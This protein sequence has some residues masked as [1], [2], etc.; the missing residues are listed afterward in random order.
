MAITK[1]QIERRRRY[2]G[3]SDIAAICGLSP[4]ATAR[5]VW[6]RKVYSLAPDKETADTSRGNYLEDGLLRFAEQKSGYR[7]ARNQFRTKGVFGANLDGLA[8]QYISGNGRKKKEYLP[9]GFEAKTTNLSAE[10]GEEDTDQVPDYVALQCHHQIYCA[11]LER[12]FVPV[13]T[14]HFG[15]LNMRMYRIERDDEVIA[16]LVKIGTD[17][18]NKHIVQKEPPPQDEP[19]RIE[20]LKRI[21]RVPEKTTVIPT[22]LVD[23]WKKFRQERLDAEKR[24]KKAFAALLESLEDAEAGITP[25]GEWFTYLEQKGADRIDR[26]LLKSRFPEVYSEVAMPTTYRVARLKNLEEEKK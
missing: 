15:R 25:E 23:N 7:I 26:K 19:A 10:W 8:F 21:E 1:K 24:E 3:S 18:W 20:L 22:E 2:I 9:V 11:D 6:V 14:T 5:D 16:R 13:L 12:V 4:W 17:W